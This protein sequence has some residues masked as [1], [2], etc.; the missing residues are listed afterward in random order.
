MKKIKKHQIIQILVILGMYLTGVL[1]FKELPEE[2]PIHWNEINQPDNWIHKKFFILTFPSIALVFMILFNFFSLMETRKSKNQH[3]RE[4]WHLIQTIFIVFFAYIYMI[5]LYAS[6]KENISL[7]V[8]IACGVGILLVLV[9]GFL[10]KVKP[11]Y[12]LK[13]NNFF[14]FNDQA[15]KISKGK[16]QKIVGWSFFLGGFFIIIQS[17]FFKAHLYIFFFSTLIIAIFVPIF[18]S[19]FKFKKSDGIDTR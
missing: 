19:Y 2:M 18:Y 9:G 17:I 7:G 16:I 10:V 6:V 12:F 15:N 1:L 14:H 3:L 5:A 13:F 4:V 8:Y 11:D